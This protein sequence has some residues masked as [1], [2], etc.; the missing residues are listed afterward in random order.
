MEIII[1]DLAFGRYLENVNCHFESGTITGI[2]GV[3]GLYLMD[4][5]NGDIVRTS[6]RFVVNGHEISED[7]YKQYPQ[8]V[9]YI[10]ENYSFYSKTV[11]DE[12]KFTSNYRVYK[13]D[14]FKTKMN[15]LLFLVGLDESYVTREIE[16]LSSSEKILVSIALNLF[17]DPQVVLIGD[18]FKSLDKNNTKK[19]ISIMNNLRESN[20]IVV[21]YSKDPNNVY[22]YSDITLIFVGARSDR[23]GPTDKVYSSESVLKDKQIKA[24][25]LP[26]IT[27][28]ARAKKV[29]LS[30]HKDVRDIIKDV[31]KHV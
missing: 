14:M 15:N 12:F 11:Y 29:K 6:G 25:S 24:P 30:F 1:K 20:K 13:N 26:L 9:A 19:L 28:L 31:Y 21:F 2:T 3:A 5:L 23:F 17:F 27:H 18:I 16:S 8:T 22:D 7:F 4:L 10:S